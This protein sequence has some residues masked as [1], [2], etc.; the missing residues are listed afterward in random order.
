MG[1]IVSHLPGQEGMEGIAT[2]SAMT[3]ELKCIPERLNRLDSQANV[4]KAIALS[5][6]VSPLFGPIVYSLD[7]AA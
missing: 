7:A 3:I 1:A 2:N 5:A 4:E 6:I